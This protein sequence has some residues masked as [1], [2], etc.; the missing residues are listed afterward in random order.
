MWRRLTARR[1][2]AGHTRAAL[3]YKRAGALSG[4]D[5]LHESYDLS[6]LLVRPDLLP[7]LLPSSNLNRTQTAFLLPHTDISMLLSMHTYLESELRDLAFNC[8]SPPRSKSCAP[9]F[10]SRAAGERRGRVLDLFLSLV[11]G[12]VSPV[13]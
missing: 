8:E 12:D 1:S 6:A 9:P 5:F 2:A 4:V 10:P 7:P 3:D 11:S 13:S